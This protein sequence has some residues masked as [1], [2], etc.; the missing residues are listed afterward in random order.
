[1]Q[2]QDKVSLNNKRLEN[3]WATPVK[4][5]HILIFWSQAKEWN[6]SWLDAIFQSLRN[7]MKFFRENWYSAFSTDSFL[8]KI[9]PFLIMLLNWSLT[10][11]LTVKSIF[12]ETVTLSQLHIYHPQFHFY[13]YYWNKI[14]WKP[15]C[16]LEK[17]FVL[18][19]Q[20]SI[21]N[22]AKKSGKGH[23]TAN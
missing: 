18:E 2:L 17:K 5:F 9:S 21:F 11:A 6:L 8:W 20:F 23:N 22:E 7:I 1:M 19:S 15:S 13:T 4:L 12:W 14:F 3:P 16:C 10:S